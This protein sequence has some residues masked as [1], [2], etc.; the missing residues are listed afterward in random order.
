MNLSRSLPISATLALAKPNWSPLRYFG[1]L[2]VVTALLHTPPVPAASDRPPN[3]VIVYADDLG[4]GD[5]G[6]YGATLVRTPNLDRLAA[7]G[8]RFTDAYCTSAICTPSRYS[9]LTGRYAWREPGRG[10]LTGDA[11]MMIQPGTPTIAS[12]LKLAG[13]RTAVI[14]KWHLGLG[15]GKPDWN[16]TITP[17]PESIGFDHHFLI[18]A[19]VDRVPCVFVRNGKVV[20]LDPADPIEVSYKQ[21]FAGLPLGRTHPE[22]L[23]LRATHGHDMALIN[24]IGRIGYMKGGTAALWKDEAIADELVAEATDWIGSHQDQPFF[25]LFTPHDIHEPRVPH[26]RFRGRST[27]GSRGDVIEQLDWQLGAVMDALEKHGLLEHTLLIFSS[28]NGPIYDDGYDQIR[29]ASDHNHRP[30]GPFRGSKYSVLEAG[31]RM[32]LVVRWP[33]IIQPGVSSALVSQVDFAATFAAVAGVELP[34]DAAADSVNILG[35]LLGKSS[36]GRDHVIVQ[37]FRDLALREGSW[38]FIPPGNS[39]VRDGLDAMYPV[40]TQVSPPG[41]LF[42]LAHDPAE[43]RDLAADEPARVEAMARRLDELVQSGRSR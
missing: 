23:I 37:G 25:L 7:E 16:G 12:L 41:L 31:T 15:D 9:L 22:Q 13:Y 32:P 3:I 5:A 10:V 33:R 27:H 2:V 34:P 29:H 19:T 11:P 18:P 36:Q 4:W 20:G 17:G 1:C 28:D 21:P 42:N 38:K 40:R 8:L 43:A 39:D 6:C 24:G 14:G 35:A 30:A 26:P